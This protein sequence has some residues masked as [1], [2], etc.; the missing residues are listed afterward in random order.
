MKKKKVTLLEWNRMCHKWLRRK[1]RIEHD[2]KCP[3][4]IPEPKAGWRKV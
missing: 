4:G 3:C 1:G 2:P